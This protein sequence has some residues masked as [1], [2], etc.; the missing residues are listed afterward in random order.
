MRGAF[1][2]VQD[3]CGVFDSTSQITVC[4]FLDKYN[5]G[6]MDDD[7]L[8]DDE[9]PPPSD[10]A[11]I[12]AKPKRRRGRPS[13]SQVPSIDEDAEWTTAMIEV[14][15]NQKSEHNNLFLD[16]RNKQSLSLGWSKVTLAVNTT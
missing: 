13:K 11:V 1:I 12:D 10:R 3:K 6:N 4:W 7:A 8:L 16:A 9:S 5:C 2:L 14:L 15:V